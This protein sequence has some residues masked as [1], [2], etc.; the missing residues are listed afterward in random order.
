MVG[1]RNATTTGSR[2][3]SKGN[4]PIEPMSD[5]SV[6]LARGL[7]TI[8]SRCLTFRPPRRHGRGL[9]AQS[10]LSSP[11]RLAPNRCSHDSAA[12]KSQAGEGKPPGSRRTGRRSVRDR[13]GSGRGD[14]NPHSRHDYGSRD[15]ELPLCAKPGPAVELWPE[16]DGP[17]GRESLPSGDSRTACRWLDR[18][19]R[20]S[21]LA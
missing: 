21:S 11:S 8:S 9:R 20:A 12:P 4:T 14:S 3:L 17:D 13:I 19:S 5:Q 2:D 7:R 15:R 16:M 18:S 1:R 10:R 6:R